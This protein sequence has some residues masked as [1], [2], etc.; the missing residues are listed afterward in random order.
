MAGGTR[1]TPTRTIIGFYGRAA[2]RYPGLVVGSLLSVPVTTLVNTI[3]PP[4]IVAH[5]LD[6]LSRGQY[7]HGHVWQSFGGSLIAYV[8]LLLGGGIIAWRVVDQYAWRLE[9][10]VQRD[11]ARQAFGHL[12]DESADFHADSFGGSLVSDTS[13][14]LGSYIR[15]ADTTLFQVLPLFVTL[16]SVVI[17]TAGRSALFAILLA[18]FSLLYLV[19]ATLISKPVRRVGAEHAASESIQTGVL[20]DAVTNVMAIKSFAREGLERSRF[21]DRTD[22]T[23]A[24]LLRMMT[25][26]GRQNSVFGGITGSIS[27]MAFIVALVGVVDHGA[28]LGT[29][30]LVLT[31]A[32]NITQQLFQFSNNALRTY[33]RAIGDADAMVHL[34]GQQPAVLDPPRPEPV[35]I[36]AGEIRFEQVTFTH[37]GANDPLFTDLDLHIAAGERI[38]LVGHSG[39]GKSTIVRLLLRF[40]DL[41]GGRITVDGQDIAAIS[42][43]DLHEQIAYVPQ[44]PLLFHRSITD[45]I[46]Y[47]R[48]DA[49]DEEILAAARRANA[50]EFVASLHHGYRTLVG[51]R[52]VKLSGGQRQR[53]AIARAMIK[54]APV[55]LLDEATSALDSESELLIQDALWRL[56]EGR[57]AIVIA[58]RLSTVRRMD[59][60]I[61]LDDGRVAE[62]GTHEELLARGGTYAGFWAHQSGGLV[63]A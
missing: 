26:H 51:E 40:A 20:A 45:N 35:R 53:I 42:Q 58:H 15:I 60:I 2:W 10:N 23:R 57:T 56:M 46:A 11:L 3:F 8:A 38:G 31:Y 5:A 25:V 29:V 50:A 14:L 48:L 36:G 55:L 44:E 24:T 34:L 37:G 33:N 32:T 61:V 41:D 18:A 19:V 9:A 1:E 62:I 4:L 54:D 13:K 27:S 43:A 28:P 6:R 17:V 39:A 63:E 16:V 12:V 22:K 7:H 52:G 59:R 49:T 47:G 21:A 30:F